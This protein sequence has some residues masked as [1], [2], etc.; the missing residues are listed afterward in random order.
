MPSID[1]QNLKVS[2]QDDQ[3]ITLALTGVDVSFVSG[4]IGA[5]VGPSGSGKTTLIKTICGFL[6]Y[7]GTIQADGEDYAKLDFKQR[8]MSY[9]DQETTLNPNMDLYGNIASPLIIKK[10]KRMEIDRQVKEIAIDL[11]IERYLSLF[12]DQVSAGQR[13]LAL[14]AKALVKKPDLVLLDEAFSSLDA[15]SKERFIQTLQKRRAEDPF[16]MLFVTHRHEEVAALADYIVLMNE[17][18]V[19]ALIE[20]SDK[21]FLC[22]REIME[23]NSGGRDGF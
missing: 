4:K 15:P 21:R 2:Y 14:L 9:V 12:P 17:G 7:E 22:I 20:R 23:N 10:M 6:D 1:I 13:Q 16:T 8:N 3:K 18:K 5:I 11:G 19:S